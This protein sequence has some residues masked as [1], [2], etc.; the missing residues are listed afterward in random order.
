MTTQIVG[1]WN[2]QLEKN[3]TFSLF[4]SSLIFLSFFVRSS[5]LSEA[6]VR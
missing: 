6:P 5:M 1:I 3:I 4:F 2:F